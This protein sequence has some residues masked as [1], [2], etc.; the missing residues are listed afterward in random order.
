[1]D[2]TSQSCAIFNNTCPWPA[3]HTLADGRPCC[4]RHWAMATPEQKGKEREPVGRSELAFIRA[5]RRRALARRKMA[6]KKLAQ[7]R[8][9][10]RKSAA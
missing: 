2:P 8:S 1:M 7:R 3:R 9:I 6:R 10:S 4:D 5:A